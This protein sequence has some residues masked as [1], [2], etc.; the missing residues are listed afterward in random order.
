MFAKSVDIES[1]QRITMTTVFLEM[2]N[3][4]EDE[5]GWWVLASRMPKKFSDLA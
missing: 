1:R 2:R 4:R 5:K 3:G